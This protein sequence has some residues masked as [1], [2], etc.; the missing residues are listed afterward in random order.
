LLIIFSRGDG[1]PALNVDTS[2]VIVAFK[3]TTGI[4][5]PPGSNGGKCG[6][7][8]DGGGI[9]GGGEFGSGEI[10]GDGTITSLTVVNTVAIAATDDI[11]TV[12]KLTVFIVLLLINLFTIFLEFSNI[13]FLFCVAHRSPVKL[14]TF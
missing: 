13:I 9:Y 3:V 12:T 14:S 4:Y 10:K 7:G 5:L 2:P 6:G 11:P 8:V 1:E